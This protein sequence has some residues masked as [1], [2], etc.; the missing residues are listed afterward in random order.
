MSWQAT[1]A[2]LKFRGLKPTEKL[3]LLALANY[4]NED[5]QVWVKQKTLAEDTE[6]CRRTIV[7]CFQTLEAAGALT[8][9]I[10]RRENGSRSS[11][12]V[13]L[14]LEG[15]RAR[16]VQQGARLARGVVQ[17]LHQG[18][19]GVAHPEP[20]LEPS[21]EPSLVD[22]PSQGAGSATVDAVGRDD[23]Q[24]A[25]ELWNETAKRADLPPA[26]SLTP[27]RRRQ[28]TARLTAI[29]GLADWREA[30]AAV[31]RSSFCRGGGDKGWRI[32]LGSLCQAK[33]FNR[34]LDGFYDDR[35]KR[36]GAGRARGG[37]TALDQA[38]AMASFD[39]GDGEPLAITGAVH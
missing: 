11:D 5:N 37:W 34:L 25:F 2:A 6:L 3:L 18:G 28:I 23:A 16:P 14:T 20:P 21:T 15:G 39:D 22:S 35:P 27:E 24:T 1:A 8:R 30:L 19:A 33:T 32:D 29:S 4:A 7:S 36:G 9:E 38:A 10:R 13:T 17:G 12:I 31:E 26:R